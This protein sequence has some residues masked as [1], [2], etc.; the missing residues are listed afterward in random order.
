MVASNVC[1]TAAHVVFDS[2]GTQLS[3]WVCQPG[4]SASGL[5]NGKTAGWSQVYYSSLYTTY[6]T[7][8]EYDWAICVLEDDFGLGYL[9]VSNIQF[10]F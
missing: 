1:L 7:S 2:S 9:R 6:P 10:K 4:F 8:A 5:Y 3:N